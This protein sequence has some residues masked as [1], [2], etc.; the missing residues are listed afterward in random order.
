MKAIDTSYKGFLFRSRLEARW[1]VYFDALGVKWEYEVEGFEENGLR[2]LPDFFFPEYGIWGEVKPEG[3]K[4]QDLD[5]WL[6]FS[7]TKCLIIFEGVPS[8]NPCIYYDVINLNLKVIPFID[9]V[10]PKYGALWHGNEDFSG[11][12]PFKTAIRK[13]NYMRFGRNGH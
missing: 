9:K 10:N 11:I 5:K 7:K 3:H 8:I 1:A 13:A 12:E 6:M 4:N 2:Y